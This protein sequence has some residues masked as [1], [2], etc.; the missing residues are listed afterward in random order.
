MM[1]AKEIAERWKSSPCGCGLCRTCKRAALAR[2]YLDQG[3]KLTDA[4]AVLED[5][6]HSVMLVAFACW[7]TLD[8]IEESIASITGE[9]GV[10]V[11]N[12]LYAKYG[13]FFKRRSWG[14]EID[15]R[16]QN[17]AKREA[18]A[19]RVR[20]LETENERLRGALKDAGDYI[21]K[22][23]CEL[24]LEPHCIACE[25]ATAALAAKEVQG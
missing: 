19:A 5:A 1:D 22:T 20:E 13:K 21:H 25:E 18:L 4:V 16:R 10:Q 12:R 24:G 23:I 14:S 8:L 3:A 6:W 9:T 17:I 11:N 15:Q 2:A 7:D